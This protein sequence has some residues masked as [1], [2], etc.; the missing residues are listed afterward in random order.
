MASIDLGA[1]HSS[2]SESLCGRVISALKSS[3]LLNES[4]GAGY[5]ERNW[6]PALKVSGAWPLVSLRQSFLDGSLTRLVDPDG[7]LCRK[8]VEFVGKGDFGL[9]SGRGADGRFE[10][11]SFWETVSPEDVMFESD[12]YLLTRGLAQRLKAAPEPEPETPAGDE[13]VPMIHPVAEQVPGRGRM[14]RPIRS[15]R[16][17]PSQ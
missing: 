6:P 11:V 13:D 14:L 1:G 16:C 5:L 8:I 9:G 3:A 17:G 4:V 2:S 10:R 12:V 7:V 15:L